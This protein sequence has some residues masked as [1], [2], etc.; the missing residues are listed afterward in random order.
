MAT[1]LQKIVNG[2]RLKSK[3]KTGDLGIGRHWVVDRD[4]QASYYEIALIERDGGIRMITLNAADAAQVKAILLT[5]AEMQDMRTVDTE[6]VI[7][8]M[9][10]EGGDDSEIQ[11]MIAELD[12]SVSE[13]ITDSEN[14][15]RLASLF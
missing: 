14:L 3:P 7:A 6:G 10:H 15:K 1:I 5:H 8:R 12:V 9:K 4:D 2:L 13:L 11:E